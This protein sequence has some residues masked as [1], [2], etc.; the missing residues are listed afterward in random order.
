MEREFSML[1]KSISTYYYIIIYNCNSLFF[2]F[3][4]VCDE[5]A[6]WC[7]QFSLIRNFYERKSL[8][9]SMPNRIKRKLTHIIPVALAVWA[10]NRT[11]KACPLKS[12]L[13][14]RDLTNLRTSVVVWLMMLRA[15]YMWFS[16]SSISNP[17]FRLT[18]IVNWTHTLKKKKK[19]K[20]TFSFPRA[21][22][23][24]KWK[25]LHLADD[26]VRG[27]GGS[28]SYASIVVVFTFC[29]IQPRYF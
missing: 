2:I 24:A 23:T 29:H 5:L 4:Q 19:K 20:K 15:R 26:V 25:F 16:S 3:C 10:Y 8:P 1:S 14:K 7:Y 17:F 28:Y 13:K 6:K 11:M 12:Q 9:E 18:V 27:A 21:I 22:Q